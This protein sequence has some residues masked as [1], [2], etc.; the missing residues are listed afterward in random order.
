MESSKLKENI[1]FLAVGAAGANV[2][3]MMEKKGYKAYYV[4]LAKQDLDLISI[5]CILKTVRAHRRIVIKQKK[6]YQN[7]LMMFW[8]H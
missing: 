7:L 1:R 5:S 2:T 6:Y 8:R 3:Q 4:N